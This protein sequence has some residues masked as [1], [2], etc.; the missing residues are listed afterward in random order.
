M[1]LR[2]SPISQKFRLLGHLSTPTLISVACIPFFSSNIVCSRRTADRR[3]QTAVRVKW[4][5]LVLFR[6]LERPF[7]GCNQLCSLTRVAYILAGFRDD[8]WVL[9]FC[10]RYDFSHFLLF[11][12]CSSVLV[13]A[14]HQ[15]YA[16]L[17]FTIYIFTICG[18]FCGI[19]YDLQFTTFWLVN[20]KYS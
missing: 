11:I 6:I 8:R 2:G 1:T 13:I 16:K 19:F 15:R 18:Y 4:R 10:S 20:R 5:S 12:E 3:A 9:C 17:R 7:T 14:I